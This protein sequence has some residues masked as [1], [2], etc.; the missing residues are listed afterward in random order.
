[1]ALE[2][3]FARTWSNEA[4]QEGYFTGS[5]TL[6]RTDRSH[7]WAYPLPHRG[8]TKGDGNGWSRLTDGDLRSYWKS[9]P[10]LSR[11]FTGEDDA[12]HPQWIMI[13]MGATVDV[14]ATPHRLG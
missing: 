5:A 14:N 8:A 11:R 4:K 13:D 9:N 10:Y 2:S 12:R 3:A 1:M 7:S 6:G